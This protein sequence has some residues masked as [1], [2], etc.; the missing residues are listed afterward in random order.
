MGRRAEL[1]EERR[2]NKEEGRRE[3]EGQRTISTV[4]R[5][6]KHSCA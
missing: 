3:R 2:V 4:V 1:C 5:F 6:V